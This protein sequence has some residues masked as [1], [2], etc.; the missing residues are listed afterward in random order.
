MPRVRDLGISGIPATMQPPEVGPGGGGACD[1]SCSGTSGRNV[2]GCEGNSCSG[3]S[4]ECEGNSCSGS[5]GNVP[6]NCEDT[7][8]SG[9]SGGNPCDN[10]CSGSSGTKREAGGLDRSTVTRL[11][12]HL[13]E[14]MGGQLQI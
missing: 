3:S 11:K 8:C 10:S 1:S 12:R 9:T 2:G 5:S 14:R 4:G 13:R 7:S 6:K